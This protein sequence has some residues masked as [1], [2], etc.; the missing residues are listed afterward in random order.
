MQCSNLALSVGG[1]T[2]D[3]IHARLRRLPTLNR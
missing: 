2:S 1:R 3:R